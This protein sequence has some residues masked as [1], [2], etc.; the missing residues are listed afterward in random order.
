MEALFDVQAHKK[1]A[2]NVSFSFKH[3][4]LF[5]SVSLDGYVKIWDGEK[6]TEVNNT[7]SPSLIMEKYLKKTTVRNS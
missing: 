3:N 5:S 1:A 6:L 4:G 2:T 7:T